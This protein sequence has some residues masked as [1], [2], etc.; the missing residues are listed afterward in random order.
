MV[1]IGI[2]YNGGN[3]QIAQIRKMTQMTH[4]RNHLNLRDLR[5][6]RTT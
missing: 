3:P 6:G 4:L 5:I 2:V 1:S